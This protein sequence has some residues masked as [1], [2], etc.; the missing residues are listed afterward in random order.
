MNVQSLYLILELKSKDY[1]NIH[2]QNLNKNSFKDNIM[3]L[4]INNSQFYAIQI[5]LLKERSLFC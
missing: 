4:S 1:T 3:A 2:K 5:Q